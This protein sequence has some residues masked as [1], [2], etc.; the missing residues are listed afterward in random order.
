[1]DERMHSLKDFIY[2]KLA[3]HHDSKLINILRLL[4]NAMI[5]LFNI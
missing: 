1:M 3:L 5:M 2:I 4:L